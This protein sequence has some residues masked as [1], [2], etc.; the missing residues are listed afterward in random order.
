ML[1]VYIVDVLDVCSFVNLV[2]SNVYTKYYS[3]F[4]VVSSS[5]LLESSLYS[6]VY[7][8][9][10]AIKNNL[11]ANTVTYSVPRKASGLLRFCPPPTPSP[12]TMKIIS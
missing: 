10:I 8:M 3:C 2:L 11:S 1:L 4:P 6:D 9:I 12:P 7:S 5:G